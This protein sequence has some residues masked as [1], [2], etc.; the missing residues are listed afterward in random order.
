M[1]DDA[2]RKRKRYRTPVPILNRSKKNPQNILIRRL[3][4][5]VGRESLMTALEDVPDQRI[6]TLLMMMTDPSYAVCTLPVLV[7]K[8]GLT[9]RDVVDHFRRYKLDEGLMK[10][11]EHVPQVM[12]DVGEDAKSVTKRCFRCDGEKVITVRRRQKTCPECDGKGTV[13]LKGDIDA[14]KLVFESIGLTGKRGPLIAQQFNTLDAGDSLEALM[15]NARARLEAPKKT[16]VLSDEP[17]RESEGED[18]P[19]E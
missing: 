13:R 6:Q 7:K 19:S 18:S 1:K 11:Y 12:D 2:P 3:E 17:V 10:F 16:E 9:Y 5:T 4:S 15:G 14:R 8:C